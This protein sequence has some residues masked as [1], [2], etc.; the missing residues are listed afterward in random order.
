MFGPESRLDASTRRR[1]ES[2]WASGF[3]RFVLPVLWRQEAEFR[4]LY[5]RVGRPNFSVARLLGLYVLQELFAMDDQA[6]LDAFSF[7]VRW[8]Y[9]LG[10]ADEPAYLSRRSFVEFRSRLARHDPEMSL[11]RRVFEQVGEAAIESLQLSVQQQ[12]LDST[13]IISNIRTRGLEA[14][15]RQTL[16]HLCDGL[17]EARRGVLPASLQAYLSRDRTGWFAGGGSQERR[18]RLQQLAYWLVEAVQRFARDEEVN[19]TEAYRV[20]ARLVREHCEVTP[21]DDGSDTGGKP[22]VGESGSCGGG[23][24]DPATDPPAASA[25]EEGACAPPLALEV[26]LKKPEHPG[27]A[28]QSPFD[29][30]VGYGHKGPGYHVHV[31]ETC[32]NVD[33]PE[34]ITDYEVHSAGRSDRGKA[35]DVVHRL[36]GTDR[37]PERLFADGGYPTG[38][39]AVAIQAAGIDFRAPVDRG[40]MPAETM[41]RTHFT[42]DEQG[43]V[44]NCPAGHAPTA[45]RVTNPNGDGEALHAYFDG[46]RCRACELSE[47]CPVR[48][49]NNGHSGDFRLDLRPELRRRDEMF[50]RQK[51]PVWRQDYRIRSGVEATMSELKRGHG[52]G[53]LRVRCLP[54]V[55]FAVACK[56]TACNVKRWLRVMVKTMAPGTR[57]RDASDASRRFRG[58]LTALWATSARLPTPCTSWRPSQTQCL[59]A[60][61]PIPAHA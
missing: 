42:F 24:G 47:R 48:A 14:L 5:A 32:H 21:R 27:T 16:E 13:R 20:A 37:Q 8:Q 23:A 56:V 39:S 58:F 7:D 26:A 4:I 60:P 35:E 11:M 41:S 15:F 53:R 52:M 43:H 49:P 45:H 3:R 22:S 1:L 31:T 38:P 44:R 25:A 50:E 54:R 34:I 61:A 40:R 46:D 12:R 59:P 28:L 29:P 57:G 51:D 33:K 36:A 30:D 18:Q 9:A 2:S 55:R 10:M 6:A 19:P 17:D